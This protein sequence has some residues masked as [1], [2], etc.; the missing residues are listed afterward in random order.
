MTCPNCKREV[1][2]QYVDTVP[3]QADRELLRIAEFIRDTGN[4]SEIP[5][6]EQ[7]LDKAIGYSHRVGELLNLAL[8]AM[9][10]NRAVYAEQ[11]KDEKAE[12]MRKAKLETLS[13]E[14]M[15]LVDDLKNMKTH[16]RQRIMRLFQSIKTR[17]EER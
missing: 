12:S 2:P 5:E 14:D 1:D 8:L 13:A 11:A 4:I 9:R 6:M 7:T 17:R 16:L 3:S 15:K 10:Q